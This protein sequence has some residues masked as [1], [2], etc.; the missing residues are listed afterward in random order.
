MCVIRVFVTLKITDNVARTALHTLHT[1]LGCPSVSR[2]QRSEFWELHF[3]RLEE[4]QAL[5]VTERLVHQTA[6]FMNPNKHLCKIEVH[7]RSVQDNSAAASPFPS[8]ASILVSDRIDGK[9][10]GTLEFLRGHTAPSEHPSN[11]LRGIWW[12]L[13]FSHSD[14]SHIQETVSSLAVAQSRHEGLFANPH[15]QDHRLF[16]P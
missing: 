6:L 5:Q 12:D 14:K 13:Q 15:Y 16:L 3:P 10:D 4:T 7:P 8:D 11:L 9:A 1:R 2:L